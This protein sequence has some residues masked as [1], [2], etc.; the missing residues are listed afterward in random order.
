MGWSQALSVQAPGSTVKGKAAAH[1]TT[2][3]RGSTWSAK[4]SNMDVPLGINDINEARS[5]EAKLKPL[6]FY[7]CG[8][9][10]PIRHLASACTSKSVPTLVGRGVQRAYW[11]WLF[12]ARSTFPR[13]L[14]VGP[15]IC[16]LN[17]PGK[18]PAKRTGGSNTGKTRLQGPRPRAEWEGEGPVETPARRMPLAGDSSS[19]SAWLAVS[20]MCRL[21]MHDREA[22]GDAQK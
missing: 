1:C 9:R 7:V 18:G 22:A 10:I 3:P 4:L 6:A 20:T 19:P 2:P 15:G 21:A 5:V 14:S 8:S 17:I 16:I 13:T 11:L 12:V